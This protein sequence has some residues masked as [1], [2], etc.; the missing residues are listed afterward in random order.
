MAK[1]ISPEVCLAAKPGK[2]LRATK[3]GAERCRSSMANETFKISLKKAF[4]KFNHKILR[5]R[6]GIL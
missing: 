6:K 4:R 5:N 3:G 2:R 1:K